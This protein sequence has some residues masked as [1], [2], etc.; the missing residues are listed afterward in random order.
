M[1]AIKH[2][3]SAKKISLIY[4]VHRSGA[5]IA[6][7]TFELV[8]TL[9]KLSANWSLVKRRAIK[10]RPS[11]CR[12]LALLYFLNIYRSLYWC[13]GTRRDKRR[14]FNCFLMGYQ[15]VA[16]IRCWQWRAKGDREK[17]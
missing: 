9:R 14:L 2:N 17:E 15:V 5:A 4:I 11:L 12:S 1:K 13:F 7:I 16:A 8:K 10:T 6:S 3:F